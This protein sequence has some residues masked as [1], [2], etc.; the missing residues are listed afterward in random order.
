M[1]NIIFRPTNDCNL[2]CRYCYDENN[3][4]SLSLEKKKSKA[5]DDFIKNETFIINDISKIL[6]YSKRPSLIFHGGEPL[7]VD[8][9]ALNNFCNKLKAKLELRLSIQTN[10]TLIDQSAIDF[11]KNHNI[12][13][14]ISL[15]GSD[16]EQ[17]S[18]RIGLNDES[19]FDTVIDKL[20]WLKEEHI[21]FGIVM[22]ISRQHIGKEQDIYN[23]LAEKNYNCNIRPVFQSSNGDY[24]N[25]MSPL[26]YVE[27]F[28]NLFDIWY[29]DND[30]RVKIGQISEFYNILRKVL[31]DRKDS[32]ITE[33]VDQYLNVND[34]KGKDIPIFRDNICSASDDCFKHFICL[35]S[36]GEVY[37]CNRL[38]GV[39]N[40]RYGN[41]RNMTY[42]ELNYK[43]DRL[44]SE[45]KK[46]I[47]KSCGNCI[48]VSNCNGG[49]P[50][51]AYDLYEDIT[52]KS[53][54]CL[55]NSKIEEHVKRKV[56][57]I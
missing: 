53:N 26:E 44:T 7:L 41:I 37:A 33:I 14:G 39:S 17:N 36:I 32:N 49:C 10:A 8:S 23:F 55:Y 50:A 22:S 12:S 21:R 42:Q 57:G 34:K 27:F 52:M 46:A 11:L 13:V 31:L 29:S 30:E 20:E 1:D 45:R 24:S 56:L 4:N 47:D 25:V 19:T 43:I 5:T 6:Q 18:E 15:D 16:K 38:Y 3:H 48:N 54:T 9:T 2:K 51:E 40:F 35:D 28:N